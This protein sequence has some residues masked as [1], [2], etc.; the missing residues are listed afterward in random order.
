MAPHTCRKLTVEE[1][2]R[3]DAA[4]VVASAVV[5]A[6]GTFF[7][8]WPDVSLPAP[9][10]CVIPNLGNPERVLF[11]IFPA[12]DG[13]E[14]DAPVQLV[15]RRNQFGQRR[16]FRCV[17]TRLV[18]ALYVTP[19]GP[20]RLRCRTCHDLS[21]RSRQRSDKRVYYYRRNR[22]EAWR[23]LNRPGLSIGEM[24]LIVRA[25]RP[26][27]RELPRPLPFALNFATA[28]AICLSVSAS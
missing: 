11:E 1:C 16:W 9:T 23:A 26:T 25:F 4:D 19:D 13:F 10:R 14:R 7:G 24:F 17:C 5:D 20:R 2:W 15:V 8:D 18:A 6:S 22:R 27:K 28:S 12:H 21:Y 3:L